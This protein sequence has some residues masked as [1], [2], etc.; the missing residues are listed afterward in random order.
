[1]ERRGIEITRA[2]VELV[3]ISKYAGELN[4]NLILDVVD[5][6]VL[7]HFGPPPPEPDYLTYDEI[8]AVIDRELQAYPEARAP[9]LRAVIERIGDIPHKRA[10]F[11]TLVRRAR[12]ELGIPYQPP[13]TNGPSRQRFA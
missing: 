12:R 2:R 8:R 3:A 1:M 9:D 10:S 6:A 7:M 13:G 11:A 4:H 5:A